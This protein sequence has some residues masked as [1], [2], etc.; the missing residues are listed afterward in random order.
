M[1][2]KD[3]G[4]AVPKRDDFVRVFLDR[5]AER[6]CQSEVSDLEV[7]LETHEQVLRLQIAARTQTHRS[8]L[9]CAR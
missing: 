6:S 4:R 1:T 3:L 8:A 9:H 5:D 7:A 2:Q